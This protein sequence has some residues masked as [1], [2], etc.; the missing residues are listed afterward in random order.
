MTGPEIRITQ[1]PLEHGTA[2]FVAALLRRLGQSKV[3]LDASELGDGDL[4][5]MGS[6]DYHGATVT[7]E[8]RS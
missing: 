5:V 3:T 1:A 6:W 2:S 8:I 4:V 7:L